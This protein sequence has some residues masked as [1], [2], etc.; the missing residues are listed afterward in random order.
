MTVGVFL[1]NRGHLATAEG[2]RVTAALAEDAGYDAL[3]L[4]DH[5]VA[6]TTA[7]TKYP[8]HAG[9]AWTGLTTN[10]FEM[11]TTLSYLAGV[12]RHIR[13]MTHVLVAPYRH[14]VLAAKAL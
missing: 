7:H 4:E 13:L 6:P 1:F 11:L 9:G 5:I 8:Y 3:C 2:L 10:H 12:T 14:P